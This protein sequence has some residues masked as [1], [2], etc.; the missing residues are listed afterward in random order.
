MTTE[1][2]IYSYALGAF[3]TAGNP[4]AITSPAT[5]V[6]ATLTDLSVPQDSIL[7]PAEN[8]QYTTSTVD[9]T[10]TFVG[11]TAAGD[12]I[13]QSSG[14]NFFV[15]SNSDALQGTNTTTSET[16]YP[17]CFA[18]GTLIAT[19]TGETVVEALDIGDLVTTADGRTVPIKWIG[20]QTV[21]KFFAGP[22]MEPVRFRAGA[23]GDGLPHSD[24]TVTA[25]HGMV[26]DGLVINASALING[27][28][29]D[30]VPMAELPKRVTYYHIETEAHDVIL[31]NGAPAETFVDYAG[32]QAFDNYQEYV[33]LYGAERII[34]EMD[35]PRL[36]ALRLV[37]Q[38]IRDRLGIPAE[39]EFNW[40]NLDL[41]DDESAA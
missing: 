19:P 1:T 21:H 40:D 13:T 30:W 4:I 28:T 6:N 32:R 15:L 8:V 9:V 31:A 11:Q 12:P 22:K 17:Y 39:P 16:S 24:L 26:L 23:L 27:T 3:Y 34:H 37:P 25:D 36:S 2:F 20:R 35:R 10:V 5:T 7:L 14:G 33:D 41:W 29:I 18:A 38:A